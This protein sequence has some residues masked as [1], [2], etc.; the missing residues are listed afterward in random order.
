MSV[1]A[2]SASAAVAPEAGPLRHAA[3]R[4]AFGVTGSFA[5]A[6]ALDWDFTF[7]G[8]MLVAQLLIKMQRPPTIRQGVALLIVIA[9]STGL[10]LLLATFFLRTPSAL[11]LTLGLL[12]I[13][14]Y[15]AQFRGAPEIVTLL[16][17]M[18][19]VTIPVFAVVSTTT[20]SGF[21]STLLQASIVALGTIWATFAIFPAADG[22]AKMSAAAVLEP[23]EPAEAARAAFR[24]TFI[25]MPVLAW[26]ILDATQVAVVVLITIVTILRQVDPREGQIVALS[27]LLGNVVGGLAA[28]LA[29]NLVLLG[30][31]LLAFI[32]ICL[33]AS[34]L[35][36]GRIVMGGRYAPVVAVAFATFILL[37][38]MGL[39][40]I[41][42]GSGE[43]F[44]GRLSNML[45]AAAYTV[46]AL[47]VAAI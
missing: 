21:A 29:Y 24:N 30:N 11:I 41:P 4:I 33:V 44:I 39:T 6:E 20:A 22:P 43:A 45:L 10:V 12:L 1:E 16:L 18:S 37:L 15:Y 19:A 26:Y 13:L 35:F 5:L 31:S 32:L 9:L 14:A 36:A 8:P 7:V 17:Q 25:L 40:P 47:S 23:L 34:L 28:T 2:S 38:G 3:F 27:V 46:G 42:G